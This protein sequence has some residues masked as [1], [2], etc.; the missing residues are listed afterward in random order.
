MS[1]TISSAPHP[2]KKKLHTNTLPYISFFLC[3]LKWNM[4]SFPDTL[5]FLEI[6]TVV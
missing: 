3:H 6:A 1:N 2:K 4:A 5:A